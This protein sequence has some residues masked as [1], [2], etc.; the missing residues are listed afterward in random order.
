MDTPVIAVKGIG[1]LFGSFRPLA[2]VALSVAPGQLLAVVGPDGAG[3]TTL[4]QILAGI[5]PLS[6]GEGQ[7]L[8]WNL[9][10]QPERVAAHVG[11]MS[12]GFTLYDR[13]T[14]AENI[15]FAAGIRSVPT[16]V[17]QARAL[18]LLDMAGL[19]H[20]T[21]RRAG[22]LSGGMR[23][24]LSLVCNLIHEPSLL[25]LDEPG[26]GVDPLSR[27]ELWRILLEFRAQGTAVV[28][29]TSYMDEAERS[30][31]ILL[32]HEG[33]PVAL[34]S[35]DALKASCAG[36]VYEWPSTSETSLERLPIRSQKQL[37]DRVHVVLE[38]AAVVGLPG[39]ARPVTPSL[40]DVFVDRTST[41]VATVAVP[42]SV[43]AESRPS[44]EAIDTQGLTIQ[45]GDFVAV[46]HVSVRVG[47]GEV[48]AFLGPN[49][50][51]KTTLIRSLCGLLKPSAGSA[52]V[53]GA[54][55]ATERRRVRGRIGY[56]SQHFSLYPDL[57]GGENL[58]FFASVYGL[59]RK[60]A[61]S[62]IVWASAVAG[63]VADN[64][65]V[66]ELSGATRQRLALACSLL[67]RPHILFLDEPT[68]GVDPASRYRFWTV[69]QQLAATGI[70]VV[71]STHYLAEAE[72][73]HRLCLMHNGRLFAQGSLASLRTHYGLAPD[74]SVEDVFIAGI[75]AQNALGGEA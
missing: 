31:R 51:G 11:Y 9:R 24:K 15:A 67:H 16:T 21:T 75:A 29:A 54:D 72:Y 27:R 68:S 6:E 43:N 26:L 5:L 61:A 3:K 38:K 17:W 41:G 45:F 47:A 55:V 60:T 32:L 18:R 58:A 64:R 33:R 69:I 59:D 42:L 71:V 2:D 39:D 28:V 65:W 34:D 49:G 56:M 23:K 52:H 12:Q 57:T 53:A 30:D 50:A 37:A 20:F 1:R 48:V 63:L 8:G 19:Q 73:C 46:D 70:A 35:P 4:L 7:V 22:A 62:A 44:E 66:Y 36:R 14:V 40:E 25:L 74:S 10:T 13:L